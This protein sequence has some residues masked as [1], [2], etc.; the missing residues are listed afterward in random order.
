V[1]YNADLET[2]EGLPL[3]G[4]AT[5]LAPT[6]R[7][8]TQPLAGVPNN[9]HALGFRLVHDEVR[10]LTSVIVLIDSTRAKGISFG[11]LADYVGLIGMAELRLDAKVGE[12]PT[13]LR[14]FSASGTAPPQGLTPWDRSFLKALYH[15]EQTDVMQ[16]SEIKISIVRDVGP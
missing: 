5:S 11:Q 3:S 2:A 9:T 4:D 12:A 14:L 1:W 13:I 8:T 15:T 16:L 10:D 7:S 6:G